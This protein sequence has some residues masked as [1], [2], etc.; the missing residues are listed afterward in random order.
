MRIDLD[1]IRFV[2]DMFVTVLSTG[3]V[4]TINRIDES[5]KEGEVEVAI[6]RINLEITTQ[7]GRT[8]PCPSVIGLGNE[9]M[10][11]QT[12]HNEFLGEVLDSRNMH[13]CTIEVFENE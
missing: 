10:E 5:L 13:Y 4:L 3:D 9:L 2:S 1:K 12:D 8:V 11:I 7:D 6:D